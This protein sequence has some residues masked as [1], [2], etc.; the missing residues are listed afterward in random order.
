MEGKDKKY[1]NENDNR[2][3]NDPMIP[4]EMDMQNTWDNIDSIK[5]QFPSPDMD[6][7]W[8]ET[9][10][11]LDWE[12]KGIRIK[13]MRTVFLRY[14]AAV[15]IP[16]MMVG[17]GIYYSIDSISKNRGLITFSSVEG[18]RTKLDLPDGSTLW[19]QPQT[20]VKYPKT[21]EGDKREIYFSGQAYFD[22]VNDREKPFIVNIAENV[23]ISVLGTQFYIRAK[24]K[25]DVLEAGLISGKIRFTSKLEDVTLSP[26]DVV[27]FS[28]KTDRIL[29]TRDMSSHPFKWSS[30]SIVFDNC[31]FG[32]IIKELSEWYNFEYHIDTNLDQTTKVTLT[33]KDESL[34]EIADILK[35]VVPFGYKISN[36]RIVYTAK[37]Q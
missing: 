11:N 21:F 30:H 8:S 25:D 6:K 15:A 37:K 34:Q 9:R 18:K 3:Q 22:I 16:L 1:S 14:A 17:V 32:T 28:R 7:M 26:D 24:E 31:S 12:E 13:R 29:E 20:T 33:V 5:N 10:Q 4:S 27:L 2:N 19:L 23:N 36:N 35:I